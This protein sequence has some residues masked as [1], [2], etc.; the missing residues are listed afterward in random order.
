[1]TTIN[2]FP[3]LGYFFPIFEKGQER[4]HPIAPSSYAPV[5]KEKN[6]VSWE[7]LQKYTT[8]KTTHTNFSV[9]LTSNSR[10]KNKV[11]RPSFTVQVL[12]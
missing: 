3:R 2:F 1:M 8:T 4:R 6:F 5:E 7:S 11:I 9:P 10:E 12:F